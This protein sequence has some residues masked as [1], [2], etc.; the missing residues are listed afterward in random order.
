VYG[1]GVTS[2]QSKL[3]CGDERCPQFQHCEGRQ[4][5]LDLYPES[6]TPEAYVDALYAHAGVTPSSAERLAAIGEFNNPTGARARVL[7]RVAESN[8]IHN[9]EFT[10]GFVL[11]EYFGYLKRNP[12]DSPDYS[13]DGFDF[14]LTKLNAFNGDYRRAEMVKA[15]ISSIEYRQR[16]GP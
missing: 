3:Q 2:R 11:T 16:F 7:R 4:E 14:W 9:G 13:L 1:Y 5:F 15:F 10:R 6:L 8:A 12:A